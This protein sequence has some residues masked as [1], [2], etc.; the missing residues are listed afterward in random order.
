V[1]RQAAESGPAGQ[2]RAGP[3]DFPAA[4]RVQRQ[5]GRV[6]SIWGRLQPRTP[7]ALLLQAAWQA[8]AGTARGLH[9]SVRRSGTF[10]MSAPGVFL[11]LLAA[12]GPLAPAEQILLS[13]Q[14]TGSPI[15]LACDIGDPCDEQPVALPEQAA[16]CA[17][18]E[19][20]R[21]TL[22]KCRCP[23]RLLKTLDL[24]SLSTAE[25]ARPPAV[26][27]VLRR[28]QLHG[29]RLSVS[30]AAVH[31][32]VEGATVKQYCSKQHAYGSL[33]QQQQ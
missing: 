2:Q 27:P 3:S 29:D 4:V 14:T 22:D 19:T 9:V 5:D 21:P 1:Q 17:S 11:C 12:D 16:I 23:D 6:K 33:Q 10:L 13:S 18:P 28:H 24:D 15:V 32:N 30:E 26:R 7:A 8:T 25:N 31:P 20:P